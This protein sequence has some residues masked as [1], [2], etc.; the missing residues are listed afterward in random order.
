MQLP[1]HPIRPLASALRAVGGQAHRLEIWLPFVV[2]ALLKGAALAGLARLDLVPAIVLAPVLD[3][4]PGVER[5][6]HYPEMLYRLPRL[7]QALDILVFVT[8]GAWLHG[9]AI[10]RVAR[11][12]GTVPVETS[13]AVRRR[14]PFL[15][16]AIAA[17]LLAIPVGLARGLTL[18]GL[19]DIAPLVALSAGI[20]A[21]VLFFVAPAFV[22]LHGLSLGAA[23]LASVRL[24]RRLPI[25][26]PL[27]V[28][29]LS[30]LHVPGL[31]L[32]TPAIR[33]GAA[34]DPD[35]ILGAL[36]GQLPAEIFGAALSAGLAAYFAL[37]TS[38]RRPPS[39]TRA[40][41]AALATMVAALGLFVGCDASS[42]QKLAVRYGAE[43]DLER[44]RL[45]ERAL[46]ERTMSA[47]STA[48]LQVA[49]SYHRVVEQLGTER[50]VQ[51]AAS[52]LEKDLGRLVCGAIL[53]E[54]LAWSRA[55]RG[56]EAQRTYRLLVDAETPY[57][58]ARGDA[59]LG[60]ARSEDRDGRW[61]SAHAAYLAWLQG[62]ADG[63]WPL[64][65][66]G[67]SVPAY[68]ARR[69]RDRGATAARETWLDLA[70][71]ALQEAADGSMGREALVARFGL[72]VGAG[73]WE[74]AYA[75]L[76][77]LR[78][79]PDA[80][81]Q[82]GALLVAEASLLAGGLGREREARGILAGLSAE[83][84]P[85]DG[86][87][88]VT[89]WLLLGQIQARAGDLDA[90]QRAFEQAL[91]DSRSES[92]RSEATLGLARVHAARGQREAAQ[93]FYTQLRD[94]YPATPAGLTAPLEEIRL[95]LSAGQNVEARAL[96]AVAIAGYRR[97]IHQ[98]GTEVPALV[99]A[100]NLCE[101]MGLVGD[102]DRGV[103]FLDSVAGSFG[104]NPRAGSLLVQAARLS[105]EKLDDRQRAGVLLTTLR[106]RYPDSDV[107]YLARG[108]ADSLGLWDG[109]P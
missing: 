9:W 35:W 63:R 31:L 24:L 103:A 91:Q 93:R 79:V 54:A 56:P 85:F 99:A 76:R 15:L 37:R 105:A 77:A 1:H 57:R 4:W 36:L 30:L 58:G 43:R 82:G 38:H 83:K 75:T 71:E 45:Q 46:A 12:W 5:V 108:F 95:L 64:H 69:L 50:L 84:S 87:H 90:A 65:R 42:A 59:A 29:L 107:A 21:T 7:A 3:A 73:R 92:G 72:L 51:P 28:V 27:A 40:P 18:L 89:G 23:L 104:D 48:W 52:A 61:N 17:L 44:T 19:I 80:S 34:N 10:A 11:A 25:A 22:V 88:R 8:V 55:E 109:P 53:G 96:V 41:V 13:A 97:V 32:R 70:S 49:A 47:D 81:D 101:C 2:L 14:R 67:L 26:V 68:V 94:V 102:W 74:G 20:A 98:F 6:L 66:E 16:V 33:A 78:A 106:T 86:N 100:R 60:L 39:A 62:I